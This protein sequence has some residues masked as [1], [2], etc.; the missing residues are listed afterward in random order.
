[1]FI[2]E[3]IVIIISL[4]TVQSSPNY[5]P[6]IIFVANRGS[7]VVM[8][9]RGLQ[10]NVNDVKWLTKPIYSANR[11]YEVVYEHGTVVERFT[12]KNVSIIPSNNRHF[13]LLITDVKVTNGGIYKCN[14][15]VLPSVTYRTYNLT[16]LPMRGHTE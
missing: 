14:S 12:L 15:V 1:M 2:Y 13:D 7:N 9:C 10:Q 6:T 3:L 4:F 8:Q 5:S 11:N 16:V